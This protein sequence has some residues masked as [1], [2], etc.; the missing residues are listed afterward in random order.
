MRQSQQNGHFASN[1]RVRRR[2]G[3]IVQP[4]MPI[5]ELFGC[6]ASEPFG[7]DG[8]VEEIYFYKNILTRLVKK[9]RLTYLIRILDAI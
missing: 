8:T 9:L 1:L 3:K 6:E 2:V 7:A 5:R 4:F